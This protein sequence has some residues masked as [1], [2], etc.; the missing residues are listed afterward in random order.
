MQNP[1]CYMNWQAKNNF[2]IIQPIIFDEK[3]RC[4][5]RPNPK[6]KL[7]L[8]IHVNNFVMLSIYTAVYQ[9]YNLLYCGY[10][11]FILNMSLFVIIS[12]ERHFEICH[13]MP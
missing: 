3:A 7:G 11:M 12:V 10:F 9:K 2:E 4:T 8:N 13:L 1:Y 5:L 6:K